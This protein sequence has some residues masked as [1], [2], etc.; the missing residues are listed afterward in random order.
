MS[1]LIP[2]LHLGQGGTKPESI[3][4]CSKVNGLFMVEVVGVEPTFV[5]DRTGASTGTY[6]K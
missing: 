6:G 2:I 4:C 3:N 5:T 1:S